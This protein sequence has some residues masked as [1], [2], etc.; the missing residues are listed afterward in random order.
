MGVMIIS[1]SVTGTTL[2][3]D[4]YGEDYKYTQSGTYVVGA[5]DGYYID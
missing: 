3:L 5:E 2:A 1:R 4:I